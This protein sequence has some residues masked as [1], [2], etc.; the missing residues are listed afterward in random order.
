MNVLYLSYWNLNDP[1]TVATVYP[2]LKVLNRFAWVKQI[3]FVNIEREAKDTLEVGSGFEKVLYHPYVSKKQ[4]GFFVEKLSDFIAGPEFLCELI[5]R[6]KIDVIIGRGAPAGALAYL[7][8][9]RIRIPFYVESFEP[10]ADYMLE[11]KVW[12]WYDPRFLLEKFFESRQ[13]RYASGLMPVAENYTNKLINEGIRPEKVRT[14]PCGV[15]K[16]LFGFSMEKRETTRR[17]LSIPGDTIVGIY[18][19]KYG[20]L[21]LEEKAFEVYKAA[22]V[23]FKENFA[24]ILLTPEVYHTWIKQQILKYGLPETKV[25]VLSVQHDEVPQYLSASDFC[26][27]TYKPGKSKRYLS[28]VKI[29]EYW[30][31]GLPVLLTSGIGDETQI[32]QNSPQAGVLF[33]PAGTREELVSHFAELK[34]KIGASRSFENEITQL[35]SRHRNAART[36]GVY[37][38][39]LNG[40]VNA[41][42]K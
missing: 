32:I 13:K 9:R 12:R 34:G 19:G 20:G 29:A 41:N 1:L 8:W 23:F 11:S 7:T 24:L 42:D 26:F 25:H 16:I 36:V 10:H 28:P 21:Y 3:I 30:A 6:Y 22:F 40:R 17:H 31:N 4:F 14:V 18:A 5:G 37:E 27:A 33:D 39:F 35:V 2:N 38:Y 15:D